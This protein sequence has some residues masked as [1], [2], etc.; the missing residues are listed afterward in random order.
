MKTFSLQVPFF[1]GFYNTIFDLVDNEYDACN[2][3]AETTGVN[4]SEDDYT[5]D[6]KEFMKD[7]CDAFI[8]CFTAYMP[9]FIEKVEY[10]ELVSPREYNFET[11]RIFANMTFNDNWKNVMKD[12]FV[13][14]HIPI[15]KM[16]KEYHTSYDGFFS[17]M[18]NNIDDWYKKLFDDEDTLYLEYF[19]KY[20]III[21]YIKDNV[22]KE[23]FNLDMS[24]KDIEKYIEDIE[25]EFESFTVENVSCDWFLKLTESGINKCESN[26][27]NYDDYSMYV[28]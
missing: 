20:M 10:D 1:H 7:V 18:S 24:I 22:R 8:D 3:F 19:L 9:K 5:F 25:N 26:N 15:G 2:Y 23:D 17:Y 11:D 27:V 12:Y 21:D 16:I 13:K 28:A 14:Y 4:L 6:N